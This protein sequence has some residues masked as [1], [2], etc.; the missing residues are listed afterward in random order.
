MG[1]ELYCESNGT[2]PATLNDLIRA[3]ISTPDG[4]VAPLDPTIRYTPDRNVIGSSYVY[5]PSSAGCS[6]SED[7]I[8]AHE[9]EPWTPR[10]VCMF[11]Q[12]YRQAITRGGKLLFLDELEVE[13]LR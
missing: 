8:V 7:D 4:L 13:R 6:A 12:Y 3:G 5:R 11:P 10:D 9:R 2:P 1:S